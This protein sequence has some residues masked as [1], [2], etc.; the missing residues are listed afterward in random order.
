[1]TD[2]D[3]LNFFEKHVGMELSFNE[4]TKPGD[5]GEACWFVHRVSG[6]VN[7]REWHEVAQEYKLRDAIDAAMRVTP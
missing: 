4:S 6:G 5:D 7:D 3:R 1:M 2:T